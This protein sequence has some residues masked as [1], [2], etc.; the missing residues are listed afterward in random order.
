MDHLDLNG[1][2]YLSNKNMIKKV[3]YTLNKIVIDSGTGYYDLFNLLSR[4]NKVV[5]ISTMHG[6]GP[7]LSVEDLM[8][9]I[10]Q[11]NLLKKLIH[12][13]VLVFVLNIL[14]V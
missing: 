3:Y 11:L 10:N 9:S 8:I 14:N 13:I 6:S 1:L 5:K 7:K 12:L 2:S 4:D